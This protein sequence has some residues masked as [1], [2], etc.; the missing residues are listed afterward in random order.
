M[1]D[2]LHVKSF[3]G[4]RPSIGA[5][6]S[7]YVIAQHQ[8]N[9]IHTANMP[10]LLIPFFKNLTIPLS[11][12][13]LGLAFIIFTYLVINGASNA[14]N[15]TDGLDGLAIMPIVMVAAGLGVFAYLVVTSV[16]PITCI[17]HM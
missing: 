7:L 10:D 8:D 5:G 9:P 15:L 3:S 17:F 1:P 4:R 14:V 11:A 2:C 16:L 6:I 12:I 13:P